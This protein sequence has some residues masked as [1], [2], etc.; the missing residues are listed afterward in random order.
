VAESIETARELATHAA[1]IRH[2]Q[3]DM[4]KLVESMI[5]MNKTLL[6]IN[7]TLSEAK[8]GWKVLMLIGGAG[9]AL[10]AVL[11]QLLHS[12]PSWK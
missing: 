5:C 2:L 6:E 10:G 1:D 9:G 3:D 4:D 11:T 12:M 7:S 8:G